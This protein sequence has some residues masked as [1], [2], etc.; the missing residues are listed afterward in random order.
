MNSNLYYT[1]KYKLVT[2][3]FVNQVQRNASKFQDQ[4]KRVKLIFGMSNHI[5][6]MEVAQNY[7][8]IQEK[9]FNYN[10]IKKFNYE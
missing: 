8:K 6:T 4:E 7:V 5:D 9:Y 10:D 3:F 1:V 2:S